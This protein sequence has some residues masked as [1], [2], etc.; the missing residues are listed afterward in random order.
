MNPEELDVIIFLKKRML[1]RPLNTY[2]SEYIKVYKDLENLCL[3]YC[4]HVCETDEI[5]I[6]PEESMT[7]HYC[8]FCEC[9]FDSPFSPKSK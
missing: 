7:I 5:D 9:S 6:S 1:S 4:D 8:L 2:S 3:K